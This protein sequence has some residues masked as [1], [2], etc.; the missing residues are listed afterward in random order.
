MYVTHNLCFEQK[1]ENFQNFSSESNHFL[2]VK[3]SV[4]LNRRVFVMGTLFSCVMYETNST[5]QPDSVIIAAL[6]YLP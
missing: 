5:K 6:Q 1:Y 2:V 4:Y 3:F